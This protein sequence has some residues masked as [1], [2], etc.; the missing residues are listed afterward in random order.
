VEPDVHFAVDV[1]QVKQYLKPIG[2]D[3]NLG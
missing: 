2:V 3:I 1:T